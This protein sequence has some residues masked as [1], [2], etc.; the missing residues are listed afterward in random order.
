LRRAAAKAAG[1]ETDRPQEE[2]IAQHRKLLPR[3]LTRFLPRTLSL[4]AAIAFAMALALTPSRA[5]EPPDNVAEAIEAAAQA[6]RD[7]GGKADT[8]AVL[9]VEDLN[10]DG[11]EDWLADYARLKCEG[12]INPLCGSGGCT[13]QIYLWDGGTSWDLLFEDLVQSYKF[14][15]SGGKRM[16][17]VTTSGLPCNKPASETCKWTYRLEKD[18]I[19][20]VE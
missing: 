14:G 8:E 9:K 5:A 11:G 3:Q 10:G 2:E 19:V 15:K 4:A 7:M 6:C 13:L 16:F 18:A 17:Y 12:G 1:E 20:P